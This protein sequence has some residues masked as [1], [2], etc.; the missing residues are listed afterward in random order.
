MSP[1]LGKV[2]A[3]DHAVSEVFDESYEGTDSLE[4]LDTGLGEIAEHAHPRV[5]KMVHH[6]FTI[7]EPADVHVFVKNYEVTYPDIMGREIKEPKV[8]GGAVDLGDVVN[9]IGTDR[10]L[11]STEVVDGHMS[12]LLNEECE[13]VDPPYDEI[14]GCS[15]TSTPLCLLEEEAVSSE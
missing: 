11:H 15:Y 13:K 5:F 14:G 3:S 2:V 9:T 8:V 1:I 4:R 7:A 6:G 12:D 10:V